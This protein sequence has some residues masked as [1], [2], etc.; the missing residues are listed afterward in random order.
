MQPTILQTVDNT[1]RSPI[2]R[3]RERDF[4]QISEADILWHV[5][6]QLRQLLW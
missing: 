2:E 3:E 6:H 1:V 4:Y 5:P